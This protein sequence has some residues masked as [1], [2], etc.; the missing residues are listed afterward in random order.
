MSF[1]RH[2]RNFRLLGEGGATGFDHHDLPSGRWA[3]AF[4]DG[5]QGPAR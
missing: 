5:G 4:Y 2:R 3:F 1:A